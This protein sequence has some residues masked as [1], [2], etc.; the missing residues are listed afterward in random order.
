MEPVEEAHQHKDAVFKSLFDMSVI[1]MVCKSNGLKFAQ[2]I[3]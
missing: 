3:T 1:A 2:N